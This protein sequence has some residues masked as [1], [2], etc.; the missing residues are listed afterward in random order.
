MQTF[1]SDAFPNIEEGKCEAASKLFTEIVALARIDTIEKTRKA[2]ADKSVY[3]QAGSSG[4]ILIQ[5]VLN[6]LTGKEYV[7]LRGEKRIQKQMRKILDRSLADTAAM[8]GVRTIG[9]ADGAVRKLVE[10]VSAYSAWE[11]GEGL[12]EDGGEILKEMYAAL[13]AFEVDADS[14]GE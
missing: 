10:A 4:W 13:S 12:Q 11:K 1:V 9:D 3:Q 5:M 8:R 7:A 6:D 2:L 14:E